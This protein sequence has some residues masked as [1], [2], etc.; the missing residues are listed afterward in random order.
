MQD[1]REG[2]QTVATKISNLAYERLNKIARKKGLTIY[3]LIQMVCD[4]LIRY[5]DDRHNLTP[6][7]ERAMSIFEHMIGW[8]GAFNLA[9]PTVAPEVCEATYYLTA[10]GKK[11]VRAVHVEKPFFGH[12]RENENIQQILERTIE[13]LSPQR[14]RRLRALAV[15]LDCTSLLDLFD[16]LIDYHTHEQDAAAPRHEFEDADRSEFGKKPVSTAYKRHHK[17]DMTMFEK[18]EETKGQPFGERAD[19]YMA[20]LERQAAKEEEKQRSEEAR[21]W[22]EDNMDFRPIGYEW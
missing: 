8:Q 22:L 7:M 13:L 15:E 3:E 2:Y 19:E 4:T 6:E 20:E 5:M 1:R 12:W 16:H 14:Y 21:Q 17:Q 18:W 9:D 11:G 10:D